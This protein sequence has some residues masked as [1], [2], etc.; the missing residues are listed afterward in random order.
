M[1]V[2]IYECEIYSIIWRK[3]G[4]RKHILKQKSQNVRMAPMDQ[5]VHISRCKGSFPSLKTKNFANSLTFGRFCFS[6]NIYQVKLQ[7]RFLLILQNRMTL[8]KV[9]KKNTILPKGD[10]SISSQGQNSLSTPYFPDL[11]ASSQKKCL[12]SRSQLSN[13]TTL[14]PVS[15]ASKGALNTHVWLLP[16]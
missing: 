14:I 2:P 3:N 6:D 5:I 10:I 12:C 13:C 7:K 9:P 8:W 16:M 1:K 4:S 11:G 15:F